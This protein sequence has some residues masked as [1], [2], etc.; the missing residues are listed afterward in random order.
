M[1]L[2]LNFEL[3]DFFGSQFFDFFADTLGIL[4]EL[5]NVQLTFR[6]F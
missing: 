5:L 2:L 1:G 6:R 3:Q 4:H